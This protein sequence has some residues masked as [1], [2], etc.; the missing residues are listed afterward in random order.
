MKDGGADFSR[1]D[2]MDYVG[3]RAPALAKVLLDL[4]IVTARH[5][6]VIA[7][8]KRYRGELK[9]GG[10][11]EQSRPHTEFICQLILEIVKPDVYVPLRNSNTESYQRLFLREWAADL[12]KE[13]NT[14]TYKRR[15][16]G[17]RWSRA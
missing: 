13:A 7:I 4:D 1:V 17:R 9:V 14:F 3:K 15:G 16:P 10:A 6:D 11:D 12:H 2:P 5:F 8:A